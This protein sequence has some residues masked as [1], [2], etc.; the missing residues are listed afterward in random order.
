METQQDFWNTDFTPEESSP[1]T[2]ET[3]IKGTYGAEIVDASIDLTGDYQKASIRLKVIDCPYDKFKGKNL[4]RNYTFKTVDAMNWFKDDLC[5]LGVDVNAIKS[6]ETAAAALACLE[7]M[8][9]EIFAKP[10]K[11]TD[12]GKVFENA[13]INGPLETTAVDDA[14]EHAPTMD[15]NDELGF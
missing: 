13:Y 6:P 14:T 5:K 9:V 1:G 3:I 11:P 7:G 15:S 12:S 4:W 8:K 10:S 2:R